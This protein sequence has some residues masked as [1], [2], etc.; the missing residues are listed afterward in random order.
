MKKFGLALFVSAAVVGVTVHAQTPASQPQTTPSSTSANKVTVT[1]CVQRAMSESPTGTSG[2]ATAA[3]SDTQFIL[4]NATSATSTA[5]TSGTAGS[6]SSSMIAP[7]LSPGRRRDRTRSRRTLAI[8]SN[9]RHRR[10]REQVHSPSA[11]AGATSTAA[12]APK[13]KVDIDQDA[14]VRPAP[15]SRRP[16][17]ERHRDEECAACRSSGP[18]PASLW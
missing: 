2:S 7:S 6:S 15:S 11:T 1:G 5:G 4:A 9:H 3:I 13:L 10:Q 12:P 17:R 16:R 8:R 14:R 18:H